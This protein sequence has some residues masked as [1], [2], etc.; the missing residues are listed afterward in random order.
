MWTYGFRFYFTSLT[1]DLFTFPS[2][3]LFTVGCQRVFSLTQWS[4]QIH[5]KF[6]VHRVTQGTSGLA[7]AFNNG[8][9][10]LC[11][12]SFQMLCLTGIH[13]VEAL[14]PRRKTSG[15]GLSA[16][17]RHYLRNRIRFLFLTLLR[18]FTS[19]GMAYL[20]HDR[21]ERNVYTLQVILFGDPRLIAFCG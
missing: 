6:H 7:A 15:L 16:F 4:A 5:A 13:R 1:A 3:Y 19:G 14:Q 11:G 9:F 10:T 17:V 18:C 12:A 20:F 8:A 2:R 21:T